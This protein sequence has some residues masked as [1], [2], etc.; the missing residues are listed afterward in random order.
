MGKD[1]IG[2]VSAPELRTHPKQVNIELPAAIVGSKWRVAIEQGDI[3]ELPPDIQRFYLWGR[4]VDLSLSDSDDTAVD[5]T[6]I[7][8]KNAFSSKP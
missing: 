4:V 2:R 5:P 7:I 8:P 6:K 3:Q 1:G